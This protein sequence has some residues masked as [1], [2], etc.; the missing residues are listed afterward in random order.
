[1]GSSTSPSMMTINSYA[2]IMRDN[3]PS[4]PVVGASAGPLAGAG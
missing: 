1:L 3:L 2:R 4:D